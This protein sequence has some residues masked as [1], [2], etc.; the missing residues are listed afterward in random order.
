M[1]LDAPCVGDPERSR[2]DEVMEPVLENVLRPRAP[3]AGIRL[4]PEVGDRVRPAQLQRD[5]MVDLVL[6][7][8]VRHAVAG[9][10]LLALGPG[11][12]RTLEA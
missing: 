2:A 5:E 8:A 7:R 9:V 6:I 11:T 12:S 3:P 1:R 10:D 4:R